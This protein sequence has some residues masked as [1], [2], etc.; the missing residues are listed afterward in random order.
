[1]VDWTGRV[2]SLG[3]AFNTKEKNGNTQSTIAPCTVVIGMGCRDTGKVSMCGL[4]A[5]KSRTNG[6]TTLLQGKVFVPHAVRG[7]CASS[8]GLSY[9]RMILK[10]DGVTLTTAMETTVQGEGKEGHP[11]F[12]NKVDPCTSPVEDHASNRAA[13]TVLAKESSAQEGKRSS[14]WET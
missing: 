11:E 10:S 7:V 6:N 12:P 13:E 5:P 4:M 3:A 1:M 2:E 8:Q 9:L 14:M